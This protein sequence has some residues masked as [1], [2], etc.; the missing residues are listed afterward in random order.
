MEHL[1][2][3]NLKNNKI[4]TGFTCRIIF[5]YY[6]AYILYVYFQVHSCT[7]HKHRNPQI[8][9]CNTIFINCIICKACWSHNQCWALTS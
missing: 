1:N 4:N 6:A 8:T 5:C 2:P 9:H 3:N 7:K